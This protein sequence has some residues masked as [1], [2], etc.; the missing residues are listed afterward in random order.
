MLSSKKLT[1]EEL[2]LLFNNDKLLSFIEEINP[3]NYIDRD[4]GISVYKKAVGSEKLP[5]NKKVLILSALSK[6]G[7][8]KY[9]TREI[10]DGRLLE[11]FQE[12]YLTEYTTDIS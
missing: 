11:N 3:W 6:K 8:N 9:H 7:I 1:E 2:E 5:L 12:F 10:M 4:N